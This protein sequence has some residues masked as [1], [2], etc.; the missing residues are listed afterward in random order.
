FRS[1]RFAQD[2]VE[3]QTAVVNDQETGFVLVPSQV[4]ANV[5]SAHGQVGIAEALHL[6]V[7]DFQLIT[8]DAGLVLPLPANEADGMV[9]QH[10]VQIDPCRADELFPHPPAVLE[11]GQVTGRLFQG[12]AKFVLEVQL[13]MSSKLNGPSRIAQALRGLEADDFIEEPAAARVHEQRVPLHFQEPKSLADQ[14]VVEIRV[15]M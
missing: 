6:L 14:Q 12:L 3:I 10:T 2:G 15:R 4:R 7:K 9:G 13:E 5:Q 1:R 11:L 8:V